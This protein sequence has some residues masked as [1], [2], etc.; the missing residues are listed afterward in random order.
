MKK[1]IIIF[2]KY[3]EVAKVKTRL[4]KSIG[5]ENAVE[6][7]KNFILDILNKLNNLNSE[8]CI[9]FYPKDK[10]FQL[11]SWLGN[12]EYCAQEGNNIGERMKNAFC[13]QFNKGFHSVVILGSDLPDID[14]KLINDSFNLLNKNDVI[15]GPTFDGGY[16]LLGLKKSAFLGNEFTGIDWSTNRVFNQTMSI[17]EKNMCKVHKTKISRDIDNI[18]DLI[19]FYN[20]NK[21]QSTNT[22]KYIKKF[23]K[24]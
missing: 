5:K 18:D 6:L 22:V 7:Y 4:A 9:Y 1:C 20:R 2:L 24:L 11:K 8:I 19:D 16:Y 15:I 3:P 21:N 23:I 12:Y 10:A 13:N 17:L 14:P